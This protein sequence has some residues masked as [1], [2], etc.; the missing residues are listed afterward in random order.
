MIS[1]VIEESIKY[2]YVYVYTTISSNASN[3]KV[4]FLPQNDYCMEQSTISCRQGPILDTFCQRV[5]RAIQ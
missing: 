5:S 3:A 4:L 1:T 2:V